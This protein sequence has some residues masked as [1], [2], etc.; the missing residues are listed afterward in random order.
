MF[1]IYFG[2]RLISILAP[3][4]TKTIK[5]KHLIYC[6]DKKSFDKIYNNFLS[7]QEILNLAIVAIQPK[8]VFN[9]LKSKYIHIKAAGGVVF[10]ENNELLVIKR[11]GLWD[12][13]KGKVEQDETKK[14]AAIREV[15]EECGISNLSIKNK[16]SKTYHTYTTNNSKILKT[17]HWYLMRYKGNENLVPQLE[18]RITEIKW[19]PANRVKR[20]MENSFRSLHSLFENIINH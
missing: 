19:I 16:F 9:Y 3:K 4:E 14:A 15:E 12:L 17:T 7:N 8:K 5:S 20:L 11:D 13:P 6:K 1:N 10:N 2:N 18:E